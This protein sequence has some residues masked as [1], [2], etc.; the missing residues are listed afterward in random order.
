M[1]KIDVFEL[2][3]IVCV[4]ALMGMA[5]GMVVVM[6]KSVEEP[7]EVQLYGAVTVYDIP[8]I[9]AF[10][11]PQDFQPVDCPLDEDVQEFVY[12]TAKAYNIDFYF[13]MAVISVESNCNPT[14]IG[15]NSYGLMQ[16]H[17]VNHD[18][19]TEKLNTYDYL[20]PY[21]NV[22][23]GTYIFA[24]LFE[25]YGGNPSEVLMAYNMGEHG[26]SKLWD[27]G[28]YETAYTRMV[29]EEQ[30]RLMNQ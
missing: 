17:K 29:Y 18:W 11:V 28:V 16:I 25:K 15:Q 2:M 19:L 3:I 27:K 23:A 12:Y 9:T 5:I 22:L 10:E 14:L 20:D 1:K 13:L 6:N 4:V 21:Q 26:A 8:T 30:E 24:G 7:E